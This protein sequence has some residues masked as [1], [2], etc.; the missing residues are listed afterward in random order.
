MTPESYLKGLYGLQGRTAI[1]IGGTGVL[2]G[3]FCEAL[4]GAGA[5][6]LVVGRD[7]NRG[8]DC[9]QR[10]IEG[11]GSAEF[12]TADCTNRKDLDALAAHLA[13]REP[14][15]RRACQWGRRQL[16]DAVSRN[17]GRGMG[18][19]RE[20]ESAVGAAGLP[21]LRKIHDSKRDAGFDHQYRVTHRADAAVSCLHVRRDEAAV[22]NLTRTWPASGRRRAF[23]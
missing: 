10:L 5:H 18:P 22:V 21:G 16:G 11:G 13:L 20:R 9:V 15:R 1:V 3:A 19:H 7:R 4:A 12:F 17:Y 8:N 2:G 23:A 6:T 14:A